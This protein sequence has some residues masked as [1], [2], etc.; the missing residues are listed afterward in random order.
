MNLLTVATRTLAMHF[1]SFGGNES[2]GVRY[3]ARVS[4]W[5]RWCFLAA[6]LLETSYRLEDG[7]LSHI[8]NTLY[9]LGIMVPAAWVQRKIHAAGREDPPLPAGLLL[10]GGVGQPDHQDRAGRRLAAVQREWELNRQRIEMSRTIHDTTAQS[11][12]NIA[13]GI[14]TARALAGE[15]NPE[16]AATLEETSRLSRS[17]IWELRHPINMG[18]IYE[19]RELG[20]AL[21]AHTASFTNVTSVAAEMTQAGVEPPLPIEA[22][23]LL[24]SIAHNAL[25]NA[26]RHAQAHRVVVNLDCS[27]DQVRLAVSDD[28]IGLP[29]DYEARVR[30]FRNMRADTER[31]GGGLEVQSNGS[32]GGTTVTC[33]V[34]Y[35]SA[36]GGG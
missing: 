14:D 4:I 33:V 13:L 16:L 25:T 30:G 12:Y 22:R 3:A 35:R 2:E 21:R 27:D 17:T 18:G 1:W 26:M 24:F 32:D 9:L 15:A 34:P 36:L 11:A 8:L 7:A 5:L 10:C 28:A 29:A 23:G 31:M 6:I 20:W 19:G